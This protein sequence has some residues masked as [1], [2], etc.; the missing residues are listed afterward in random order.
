MAL[1]RM[2]ATYEM[3]E[4]AALGDSQLSQEGPRDLVTAL[5]F[6]QPRPPGLRQLVQRSPESPA[7]G[8]QV[9]RLSTQ[10]QARAE[11]DTS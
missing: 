1:L 5:A 8:A 10:A 4:T 3:C 2:M 6:S 7:T 11:G 9:R